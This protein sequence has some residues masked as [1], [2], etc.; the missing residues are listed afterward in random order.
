[1]EK[2]TLLQKRFVPCKEVKSIH[3]KSNRVT[4]KINTKR[5]FNGDKE[6]M[7]RVY[8]INGYYLASRS[9]DAKV[10]SEEWEHYLEHVDSNYII[11]FYE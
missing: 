9:F 3:F 2:T 10:T 4:Y 8:D 5:L 7:V 1:M 11:I 6:A